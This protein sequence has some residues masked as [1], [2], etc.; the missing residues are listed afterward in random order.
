MAIHNEWKGVRFFSADYAVNIGTSSNNHIVKPQ[1]VSAPYDSKDYPLNQVGAQIYSNT[2]NNLEQMALYRELYN[3][4][5][6]DRIAL[7]KDLSELNVALYLNGS[8]F[9]AEGNPQPYVKYEGVGS[10]VLNYYRADGT[11]VGPVFT[12]PFSSNRAVALC[13]GKL[14]DDGV[15][16]YNQQSFEAVA[17]KPKSIFGGYSN[18][19]YLW[20]YLSKTDPP[21]ATFNFI[22][23]DVVDDLL[24]YLP[25]EPE[26]MFADN[27]GGD[28]DAN[29]DAIGIPGLPGINVLQT[30]FVHMYEMSAAEMQRFAQ[31]LWDENLNLIGLMLKTFQD[32]MQ[33]IINLSMCPVQVPYTTPNSNIIIGNINWGTMANCTGSALATPYKRIDF[34]TIYLNEFW[35]NFADYSPHTRISIFLP[36]CGVQQL[37]VDDVMNGGLNLWAN[38]DVFTGA[39]QYFL[40]SAQTNHRGHGHQSVLYTWSGNMKYNMPFAG[41]D[42]NRQVVSSVANVMTAGASGIASAATGQVSGA[43]GAIS[44]LGNPLNW[45]QKGHVDRGSGWGGITGALG[46]QYPYLILERPELG[47]ADNYPHTIGQPNEQTDYLSNYQGAF[48]KVRGCHIEISTASSEELAELDRLLKEGVIV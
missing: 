36:Y 31:V 34:G 3:S 5:Y 27:D 14:Y 19:Y 17:L 37:A 29:S 39:I 48:V 21:F 41:S 6:G 23:S 28:F 9:D 7:L 11:L 15:F 20:S 38:C 42:Y 45:F 43:I 18:N 32:P 46:H 24:E 13:G 30:G 44:T 4:G 25:H 47:M 40:F 12:V 8:P 35:G 16:G 10:A 1:G 26:G 33:S 22:N 2:L